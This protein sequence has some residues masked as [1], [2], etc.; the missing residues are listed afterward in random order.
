MSAC[1][2]VLVMLCA[3]LLLASTA[4]ADFGLQSMSA[5]SFNEDG[6]PDLQAGS[7]PYEF[8]LSFA[9]NQ[10]EEENPEGALRE[11]FLDLP[12]GMVG[13]PVALPRCSGALFEGLQPHCPGNTQVGVAE[14][15]IAGISSTFLSPIYNLT[16]PQGAPA[17]IGFSIASN[18]SF[19][20]ASLR[21][22]DYGVKISDITLPT[23]KP[24]QSIEARVWGLPALPI[25]DPERFCVQAEASVE[26]CSSDSA[27]VPFLTLPSSC[28]GPLKW[29][30]SVDSVAEPEVLQS[31]SAESL[32]AG[33]VPRGLVGCAKLPFS[34]TIASRPETAAADSPTGLHFN[35]HV[36]QTNQLSPV[37]GQLPAHDELQSLQVKASSGT[38]SLNFIR[39]T[40]QV[41]GALPFDASAAE[42]QEALND[43]PSIFADFSGQGTVTNGSS[44]VL[45]GS[46]GASFAAGQHI[47]G[48]GIPTG[49]TIQ[50]VT[51]S[52]GNAEVTLSQAATATATG[53]I[54]AGGGSVTVTGGPGDPTGA[55]P[56]LITFTGTLADHNVGLVTAALSASTGSAIT[57]TITQGQASVFGVVEANPELAAAN[58]KDTVVKL[59]AGV[60][61]NPSAAT[62]RGACPLTGPEGINLPGSGEPGEGEPA[63]CPDDSKVGTVEVHTPLIDHPLPGAVYLAKQTS[64]PFGS[65]IALYIAID[66]P[67]S[68]IV[69]KLAGK[70]E[71]DPVTGQLTATF[72]NNPQVPFEDFTLNFFGGPRAT[73]TT[74]STCGTYTT[75]SDL[76]PWSTPEGADAFP[77]DSFQINTAAGGGPCVSS[78]SQQPNTP[79]FQA[80]TTSPLAGTYSSFVMHLSR[81]NGSQHI[82]AI[83]LTLPPGLTGKLAG[84]SQCSEAQLATAT[85][86]GNLGE[87]K[88]EQTSPSC[89]SNS[90]VGTD[91]AGVGSGALFYVEAPIYL[92]GPYEGAPFSLAIVTPVVAGPFDLGTVVVRAALYINPETAQVT[93]KSDPIPA[94]IK[95][96]PT[97]LRFDEARIDRPEFTLNP[98]SCEPMSVTG[99]AISTLGQAASLSSR[100]QAAGCQGLPFKPTFSASTLG[101]TS[102]A[103]GASLTVKVS[104]KYGEANIHKVALTLPLALPARLTTLQKA[105]TEAQ[106]A[107]NPA[108]CPPGSFIGAATA[109]TP[110]LD[111]ALTG[112]A[113]LV[114]HGGAAFPDVEF[115]LQG[116]GVQIT[117]DGKTDIK[118]GITFS[119]FETV[120]DAPIG[121]FE[122]VLPQGPHSVLTA[123]GNLCA[124]TKT[125][126]SSRKV[127]RRIHGHTTRVTVKVKKQVAQPLQMPTTII[128]QNGARVT[129]TT[130]IA[131][132]GCATAKAK[133]KAKAK[134][135]AKARSGHKAKKSTRR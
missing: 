70:V 90:R 16:P 102:K 31:A 123:N 25:H 45:V 119:R 46:E 96:V 61:I 77:S 95:G 54:E 36:P 15:R 82:S 65:L 85:A 83:D 26:G 84:V 131:V 81:E 121:S 60:A 97:D 69:V 52:G 117:L 40:E 130:N 118:K 75:T 93:V 78:E 125:V 33:G 2:L 14:I 112:P 113:I 107:A 68:G 115:L 32:G 105:C 74:P 8:K 104:Q 5:G 28:A 13:N 17:S 116:E 73:L 91:I 106:F 44:L 133:K 56:Y 103:N 47:A 22:F 43:L 120:P 24:I 63:R 122:T 87:G 23:D 35:L 21:P 27:P 57:K 20:E 41:S 99:Q 66:D 4:Q 114:S 134:P 128:G 67:Q 12:V 79:S 89:P 100:F 94:I 76:T 42:V 51:H 132:A 86:R 6:S 39:R 29:T 124:L 10:D 72:P 111:A 11:L 109:H 38:F 18:N 64:N 53:S 101:K 62:G 3:C 110:L 98:T 1:V 88:L 58:L 37:E 48:P 71:P 127:T 135:K 9:M 80:G 129:Q 126:T 92:A 7:H 19:Q 108:G 59:P 50:S 49:T 34:P 55:D 30:L